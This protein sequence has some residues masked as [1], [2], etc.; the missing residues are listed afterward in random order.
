MA[1]QLHQ[2]GHEKNVKSLEQVKQDG[3]ERSVELASE[4]ERNAEKINEKSHDVE[5]IKH[6][7]LEKAVSHEQES[8][9]E[10]PKIEKQADRPP[11]NTKASRKAAFNRE[12]KA[13]QSEMSAP[14]RNFSKIIHNPVVE[15]ASDAI[16]STIA[17][18]NAIVAGAV[19]AFILTGAL[20]VWAKYAG[21]PLSG[22]ESIGAF[23][24]GW[25]VGIIFDFTRIMVTGRR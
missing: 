23:V 25:L 20:Y 22:F 6:E 10:S 3:A 16:G 7:A 19:A 9:S 21:Y 18:P 5:S 11:K 12:M 15:K 8:K 24:V 1:E 4:R 14:S 2:Q 17:R 13:V